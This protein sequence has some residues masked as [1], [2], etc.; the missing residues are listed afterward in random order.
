V[1]ATLKDAIKTAQWHRR[2]NTECTYEDFFL[3]LLIPNVKRNW[4]MYIL[5]FFTG[6][7]GRTA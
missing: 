7:S 2:T 3:V 4:N 1:F 5:L 6:K